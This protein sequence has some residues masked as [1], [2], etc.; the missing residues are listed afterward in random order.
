M[1]DHHKG[2]PRIPAAP[3]AS[4]GGAAKR[5]A[6]LDGDVP[7]PPASDA[8]R[9]LDL[10]GGVRLSKS[11]TEPGSSGTCT[12]GGWAVDPVGVRASSGLLRLIDV[13]DSA[14]HAERYFA[15]IYLLLPVVNVKQRDAFVAEGWTAWAS[16]GFT[17]VGWLLAQGGAGE[18]VGG[19][20]P[21]S[22]VIGRFGLDE[23][24]AQSSRALTDE[25]HP[26]A[27]ASMWRNLQNRVNLLRMSLVTS[28]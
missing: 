2:R 21:L 10:R 4:A 20:V 9:P 18:P 25:S 12:R 28:E 17:F 16:S 6:L 8:A 19:H 3:Q 11:A 5:A 14:E 27:A 26:R 13:W 7:L 23:H 22:A 24:G 1:G 15:E